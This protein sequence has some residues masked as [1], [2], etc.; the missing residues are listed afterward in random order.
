M[1]Y[2]FWGQNWSARISRFQRKMLAAKSTGNTKGILDEKRIDS[3][4]FASFAILC[5]SIPIGKIREWIRRSR[6]CRRAKWMPPIKHGSK[7]K[8]ANGE[9]LRQDDGKLGD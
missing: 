7:G 2:G 8:R 1:R 5:G 6:S 4:F 9:E 3:A